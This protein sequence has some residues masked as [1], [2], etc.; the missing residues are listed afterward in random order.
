MG[1][2]AGSLTGVGGSTIVGESLSP[3]DSSMGVGA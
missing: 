3:V 1:V 2:D